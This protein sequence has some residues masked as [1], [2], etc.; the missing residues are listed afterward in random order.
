MNKNLFL[1]TT[2][3]NTTQKRLA[4]QKTSGWVIFHR[5][6]LTPV[7]L[8]MSRWSLCEEDSKKHSWCR[9]KFPASWRGFP[10]ELHQKSHLKRWMF[11]Q[12]SFLL[13][14]ILPI[15]RLYITYHLLREPETAI[16][17]RFLLTMSEVFDLVNPT[18]K[19]HHGNFCVCVTSSDVTIILPGIYRYI[20]VVLIYIYIYIQYIHR[21]KMYVHN[22]A[23]LDLPKHPA[24]LF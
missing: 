19:L 14:D 10:G 7:S 24:F 4:F 13:G 17:F 12:W 23:V 9:E 21:S 5:K 3:K 2:K 11:Y 1:A 18:S 20:Q 22:T 16:D 15:G 8:F 6:R